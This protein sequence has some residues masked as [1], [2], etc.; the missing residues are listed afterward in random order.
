[1]GFEGS[2][3]DATDGDDAGHLV[4][5]ADLGRRKPRVEQERLPGGV[6]R[7]RSPRAQIVL[8]EDATWAE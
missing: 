5:D 2:D 4:G 7:D 8:D 1:M 3:P 6:A